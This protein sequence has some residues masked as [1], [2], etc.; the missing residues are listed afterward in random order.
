VLQVV[1][2]LRRELRE[3]SRALTVARERENSLLQDVRRARARAEDHRAVLDATAAALVS[4]GKSG[5]A[6]YCR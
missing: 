3:A 5:A 2:E 1:R 4:L 6:G